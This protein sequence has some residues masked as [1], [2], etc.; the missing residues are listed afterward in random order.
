MAVP[1]SRI[2]TLVVVCAFGCT[3]AVDLSVNFSDVIRTDFAGVGGVRHGV[4]YMAEETYRGLNSSMRALSLAR[5]CESR[6]RIARTWYG[7][8]W[9]MP[10]W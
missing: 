3:A 5:I 4:D 1:W 10:V 9:A 7:V 2:A 8:D 6:L